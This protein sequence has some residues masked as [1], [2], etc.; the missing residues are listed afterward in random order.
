MVR[1][2]AETRT[3]TTRTEA[4][5]ISASLLARSVLVSQNR[6]SMNDYSARFEDT[7]V[8][9]FHAA[10]VFRVYRSKTLRQRVTYAAFPVFS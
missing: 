7:N 3:V 2:L 6:N 4:R 10:S 9:E 5:N 1:V 8:S